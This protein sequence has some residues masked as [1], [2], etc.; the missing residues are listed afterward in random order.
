MCRNVQTFKDKDGDE[1]KNKN[2]KKIA[3]PYRQ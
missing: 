1:D 3:F 2:N